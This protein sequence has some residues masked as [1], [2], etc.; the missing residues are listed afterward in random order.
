[1]EVTGPIERAL[2]A[3]DEAMAACDRE[4][5]H[6]EDDAG[7]ALDYMRQARQDD[8]GHAHQTGWRSKTWKP[9]N[10]DSSSVWPKSKSGR[11]GRLHMCRKCGTAKPY[12][13]FTRDPNSRIFTGYDCN[14][15]I[16]DRRMK[17]VSRQSGVG[18]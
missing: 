2:K 11:A 9:S 14:L 18:A 13:E 4:N 16:D 15:C 7:L 1:M 17:H 5:D 3:S 12:S 6:S 8:L 10:V